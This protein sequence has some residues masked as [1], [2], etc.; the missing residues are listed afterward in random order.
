MKPF[1]AVTPLADPRRE[2]PESP[3]ARLMA[4]EAAVESLSA[5]QRRF[6]RMGLEW[7]LA[8]TQHQLRYWKFVR[9]LCAVAA[10]A[11]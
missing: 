3:S 4:A 6:E 9:A 10:E 2:M 11:A 5:E 7:P 1:L 8:R